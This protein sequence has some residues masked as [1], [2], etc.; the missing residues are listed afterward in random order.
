MAFDDLVAKVKQKFGADAITTST[1]RDNNRLHVPADKLFAVFQY[2]REQA[3]FDQLSD[4]TAVD[5]LNYPNARDRFGVVYALLN[6]STGQR[7]Y[8]K[9]VLNEP[10]LTLPSAYPIWNGADWMEREI[11]DMYGIVFDGHPDLRRILMPEEF[12]AFPLRK[13]Y[14]LRGTG[15]RHNFAGLTRAEG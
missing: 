13:D 7:V 4:A 14:P 15:E 9:T 3:G 6:V 1:F 12:T 5:Y 10:D 2:L 11:Y 8:V